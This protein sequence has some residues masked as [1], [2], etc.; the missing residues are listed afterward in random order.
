MYVAEILTCMSNSV[1]SVKSMCGPSVFV[2]V[3]LCSIC[4]R[5]RLCLHVPDAPD[6]S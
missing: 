6:E 3:M 2:R 4:M 1:S 5:Q